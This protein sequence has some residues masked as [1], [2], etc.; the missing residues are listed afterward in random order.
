MKNHDE[1]IIQSKLDIV[2]C[3]GYLLIVAVIAGYY[4]FEHFNDSNSNTISD[5]IIV[6][7]YGEYYTF[8]KD[9]YKI[10]MKEY[11]ML[12]KWDQEKAIISLFHHIH[13]DDYNGVGIEYANLKPVASVTRKI[14]Q[15]M[16][17]DVKDIR[18][19]SLRRFLINIVTEKMKVYE[20]IYDL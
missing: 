10:T 3:I 19:M 7:N 6:K 20:R 11:F 13:K 2:L 14:Y 12:S 9:A 8:Q 18:E 5:T 1:K 4:I 17:G 16:V 15:N